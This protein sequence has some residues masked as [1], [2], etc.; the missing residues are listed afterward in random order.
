MN[1]SDIFRAR[2]AAYAQAMQTWPEARRQEFTVPLGWLA[3]QPGQ[4]VIDVPAGGGYLRRYLPEGCAWFGHEPCAS[5]F[6]DGSTPDTPLLPLPWADG[7]A[8]AA[9]SVAGVH[10]QAD[11]MPLFRELHRVLKPGGRFVLADVHEESRVARFLDD[12]VGGHNST[13]HHGDYLNE[14]S[15]QE[16]EAAGFQVID[17]RRERY[18]WWFADRREMCA[19]TRLLF[20]VRGL[21]ESAVGDGIEEH[22]GVTARDG[23]LGLNWELQVVLGLRTEGAPPR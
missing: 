21:S 1:Y 13:G 15:S 3:P 8:D 9:I 5:F 14:R 7:F 19:F 17:A 11:K 4:K 2:G 23:Q 18:C 12:F 10:H 22:L 16:L 6:G 20:D